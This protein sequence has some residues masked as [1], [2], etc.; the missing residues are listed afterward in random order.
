MADVLELARD[1]AERGE[2]FA[3]ATV[4]WRRAPSSGKTGYRALIM[5]NGEVRG[6][7]GGACSICEACETLPLMRSVRSGAIRCDQ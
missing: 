2:R 6:W 7:V 4:V 1:L 5:A 3:L